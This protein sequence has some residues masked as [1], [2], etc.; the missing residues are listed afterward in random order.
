MNKF[1]ELQYSQSYTFF[2]TAIQHFFTVLTV[3]IIANATVIG[4]AIQEKAA[5]ILYLGSILQFV[6]I[7]ANMRAGIFMISFIYRIFK[8]EKKYQEDLPLIKMVAYR[9]RQQKFIE[10]IEEIIDSNTDNNIIYEENRIKDYYSKK[11]N[12]PS[13]LSRNASIVVK[14]LLVIQFLIPTILGISTLFQ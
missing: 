1:E 6:I 7:L 9:L 13:L 10:E 11:E 2:N 14:I 5:Y 8:I 4:F 3:L 12:I